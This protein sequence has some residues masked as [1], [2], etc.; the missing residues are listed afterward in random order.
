MKIQIDITPGELHEIFNN[1]ETAFDATL[2]SLLHISNQNA[3]EVKKPEPTINPEPTIK[4]EPTI[5]PDRNDYAA[6]NSLLVKIQGEVTAYTPPFK[7]NKPII[8]IRCYFT[9]KCTPVPVFCENGTGDFFLKTD[10]TITAC[11]LAE[12]VPNDCETCRLVL[13]DVSRILWLKVGDERVL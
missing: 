2:K 8:T 12:V 1:T 3:A 13:T 4:P 11:I 5:N 6:V 10:T 9:G 7:F